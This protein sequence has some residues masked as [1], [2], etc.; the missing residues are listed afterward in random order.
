[1]LKKSFKVL[2]VAFTLLF[3]WGVAHALPMYYTFEGT[4]TSIENDSLGLVSQAGLIVSS[5]V[6]YTFLVDFDEQGFTIYADRPTY[7]PVDQD[8]NDWFYDE[9]ITSPYLYSDYGIFD[10]IRYYGQN[11]FGD[12][13][14]GS[15]V[16][17][18]NV[19]AQDS[20]YY[21]DA[22]Y[23]GVG[24]IG[25][26]SELVTDWQVGDVV[27]GVE[28][29]RAMN[30]DASRIIS[31]LTLTNITPA[32]VPE[33]STIILFGAGLIGYLGMRRKLKR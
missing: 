1:M 28:H 18:F 29:Y 26:N 32:P 24:G 10:E 7:I 13:T 8:I 11:Y 23:V 6:S 17:T 22:Y 5:Q 30:A 19:N 4:I 12:F 3:W 16:M 33:P 9:L 25:L 14:H 20:L 15:I 27:R 31:S 21:G 2:L